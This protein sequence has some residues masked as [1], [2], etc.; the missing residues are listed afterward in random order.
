VTLFWIIAVPFL[1]VLAALTIVDVFR[2]PYGGW[3]KAAWV[4]F[5][6]VLPVIG[7]LVYWISRKPAEDA[8]ERAYRAEADVRRDLQHSPIDRSGL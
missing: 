1:I 5:I 6:A 3:A 8:A 7:S 2:H 4:L